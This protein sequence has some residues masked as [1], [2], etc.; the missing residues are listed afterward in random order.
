MT[1]KNKSKTIN[2]MAIRTYILIITLNVYGLNISDK[3]Y[4][5]NGY[6]NKTHIHVVYKRLTSDLGT[7]TKSEDTEKDIPC[8]YKSKERWSGNA[9]IRQNRL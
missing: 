7:H 4:K 9:H 6:K 8:T 5:L 1:N 3:W 2:K